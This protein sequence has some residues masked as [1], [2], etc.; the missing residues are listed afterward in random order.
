[1]KQRTIAFAS[2][3]KRA[4]LAVLLTVAILAPIVASSRTAKALDATE[5]AQLNLDE[6]YSIAARLTDLRRQS[7]AVGDRPSPEPDLVARLH[8]ALHLAGVS[9][10]RLTRVSMQASQSIRGTDLKKQV[11]AVT[12]G[13]IRAPDLARCLNQWSEREPLWTIR[14]VRLDRI[15]ETQSRQRSSRNSSAPIDEYNASMTLE[16]IH[17]AV[18]S[19]PQGSPL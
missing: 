2:S 5:R 14:S 11:V 17:L 1:M 4:L 7:A 10:E 13:P 9:P 18:T 3:N 19:N 15:V 16:R 8:G 6:T 12:I